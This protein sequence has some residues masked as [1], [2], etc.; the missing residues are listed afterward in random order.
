VS[1]PP[2]LISAYEAAS[3]LGLRDPLRPKNSCGAFEKN[4]FDGLMF[5]LEGI[6][7]AL[8]RL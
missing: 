6:V 4:T 7:A 1:F 8:I 2:K 5:G 3:Y